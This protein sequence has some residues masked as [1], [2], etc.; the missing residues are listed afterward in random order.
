MVNSFWLTN[1]LA[2]GFLVISASV[3]YCYRISVDYRELSDARRRLDASSTSS[4]AQYGTVALPVN[5]YSCRSHDAME[6]EGN[7]DFG[8]FS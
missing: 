5:R 8:E 1:A 3:R 2:G 7:Y 4:L 6:R